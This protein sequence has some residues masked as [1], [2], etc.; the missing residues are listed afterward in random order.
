MLRRSLQD[1]VEAWNRRE[2]RS[3]NPCLL[4]CT[5]ARVHPSRMTQMKRYLAFAL[6]TPCILIACSSPNLPATNTTDGDQRADQLATAVEDGTSELASQSKTES[7]SGRLDSASHRRTSETRPTNADT[8]LTTER[9][10]LTGNS[11]SSVS[12]ERILSAKSFNSITTEFERESA[13]NRDAQDLTQL[14]RREIQ[15]QLG[16]SARLA[17][18]ICGNSLCLG[19]ILTHGDNMAYSKWS[20]VFFES[21]RTPNYVFSELTLK[22][23]QGFENR[24][25][26]STDPSVNSVQSPLQRR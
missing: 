20:D 6:C 2:L 19:T 13:S 7:A 3:P 18:L 16:N 17:S 1:H 14:Y 23:G 8:Y 9:E 12:T 25:V 4:A 26:F 21:P 5:Q 24:F 11:L 10:F 22:R 15:L